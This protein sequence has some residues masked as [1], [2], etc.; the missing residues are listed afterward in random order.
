[1]DRLA[2]GL[3][4]ASISDPADQG[5]AAAGAPSADY[6]HSVMR[7]VEGADATIRSQVNPRFL[8]FPCARA[9]SN[10]VSSSPPSPRLLGSRLLSQQLY[11]E[12]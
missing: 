3:A 5:A 6:L 12:R 9:S 4:A 8:R 11:A 7:A 1:M 2:D 10:S